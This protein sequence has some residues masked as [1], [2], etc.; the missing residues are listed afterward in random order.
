MVAAIKAVR[1]SPVLTASSLAC[2]STMPTINLTAGCLHNCAY[3][4][5]RGYRTYP[6]DNKIAVY[7]NTLEKL[8]SEL[9]RRR[10]KPRAVYFSPSSDLFQPVPEVL[11]LAD[12]ILRFLFSKGIG[13]AF[14]TKGRIPEGTLSL[15]TDNAELV[16]AQIGIITLDEGISQAFERNAAS[17]QGRLAQI[18]VLT[19]GGVLTE[20][21]LDPIL[22][23]LTDDDRSADRLFAAL[24]QVGVKR[25][26][27]GVLFLR[28]A[29]V[30]SLRGNVSDKEML[31]RLLSQYR[32]RDQISIRANNGSS[33]QTLPLEARR[34]IFARMAAAAA[35]HG[36]ELSICA[37]KNSDLARGSCNIAGA[38]PRQQPCAVQPLLVK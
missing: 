10:T 13:V 4:Y 9:G 19:K 8:R 16:R 33:V 32:Q 28:P 29:I 7:A 34:E 36:I 12:A 37:C 17:P 5:I 15:L 31:A 23:G 6:G 20:A 1:K 18:E 25:A 35:A 26:A 14:L 30:A 3:C 11:E 22:P 21:R 24:A 38:W 27:I 2:L